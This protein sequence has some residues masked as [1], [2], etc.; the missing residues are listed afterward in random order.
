ML[1]DRLSDGAKGATKGNLLR[2]AAERHDHH[3]AG[4]V[5]SE[6][7]DAGANAAIGVAQHTSMAP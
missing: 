7:D 1:Q 6:G 2:P 5:T 4:A 3:F